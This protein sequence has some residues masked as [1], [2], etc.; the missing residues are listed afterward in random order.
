MLSKRRTSED[1]ERLIAEYDAGNETIKAFCLRHALTPSNFYKRR[2]A[3]T[4]A[5]SSAFAKARR[6]APPVSSVAVQVNEVTIRCDTQ[7]SVAWVT[8]L[9]DA[10]R[11]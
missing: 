1:W 7:T 3:H 10:L 4:D 11:R 6:A 8:E 9:V 2:Q 5:P